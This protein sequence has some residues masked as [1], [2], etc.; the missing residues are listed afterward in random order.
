MIICSRESPKHLNLKIPHLTVFGNN[1]IRVGK[2]YNVAL[3]SQTNFPI[4]LLVFMLTASILIVSGLCVDA[5]AQQQPEPM[6]FTTRST[7]GTT[8]SSLDVRIEPIFTDGGNVQFIISFLQKD[9][10]VKEEGKD[11]SNAPQPE[12]L[13][14]VMIFKGDSGNGRGN[15]TAVFD[16]AA[17]RVGSGPVENPASIYT[18]QG[19]VTVPEDKP[20]RLEPGNF[21]VRV[22]VY[23]IN[24]SRL[25]DPQSVELPFQVVPEFP[26]ETAILTAGLGGIGLI[27]VLATRLLKQTL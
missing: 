19:N 12:I 9:D 4:I 16:A 20:L 17:N 18:V 6:Q 1:L 22:V 15:E 2:Y 5:F 25:V 14:D 11:N 7:D 21:L 24:S 13:Y 26:S 8:T 10:V 27:T 3:I 23:S